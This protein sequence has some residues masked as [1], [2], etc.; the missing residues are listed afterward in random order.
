MSFKHF[1]LLFLAIF[2]TLSCGIKIGEKPPEA[3]IP[4]YKTN[5]CLVKSTGIFGQYFKGQALDK[6]IEFAWDCF[7]SMVTEFKNNVRCKNKDECS[8][9]EIAKFIEDNFLDE[10][11]TA[12]VKQKTVS[13]GLQKQLMK[14]KKLF[15]GGGTEY[16]K[17]QELNLLVGLMAN[18]K[19]IFVDLN[20]SMKI[21]TLNWES[22]LKSGDVTLQ[23]FESVNVNFVKVIHHL[24]DL[25]YKEDN[26]YKFND[27][28]EFIYELSRFS[29]GDWGWVKKVEEFL[30]L[31]KK[32]KKSITGGDEESIKDREWDLFLILGGRGYIQ[33]LRYYYFIKNINP[34]YTSLKLAYYARTIEESFMIFYDL[35]SFK[36]PHQ[37]S[38]AEIDEILQSFANI[39]KDF[40]YS[41][42]LMTELMKIK[43]IIV[44][45][46]LNGIEKDEFLK[47]QSKVKA[48]KDVVE[49]ILPFYEFY[50][51]T[52]RPELL[53]QEE[54]KNEFKEGVN[55]LSYISN[56]IIQEVKLESGYTFSDLLLLVEE[57]EK[58]YPSKDNKIKYLQSLKEYSCLILI[59]ADIFLDKNNFSLGNSCESLKLSPADLGV[60]LTRAS[61]VFGQY[62]NYH[63]FISQHNTLNNKLDYEIRLNGFLMEALNF[64]KSVIEKRKFKII[65]YKEIDGLLTEVIKL[66][67]IPKEIKLNSLKGIVRTALEKI[68]LDPSS[69]FNKVDV[70]GIEKY[71]IENAQKEISNYQNTSLYFMQLYENKL[72][73]NYNYNFFNLNIKNAIKNSSD[74]SLTFG[75]RELLRHFQTPTPIS[76]SNDRKLIFVK[77]PNPY[78]GYAALEQM[79]LS[80]FLSSLLIRAYSKSMDRAVNVKSL[81][82]C[83][84]KEA[85]RDLK[86]LLI[87]FGVVGAT[88]GDGFIDSRFLEA[89]IFLP[90][91]DGNDFVSFEEIAELSNF[92]FSGF[93]IDSDIYVDILKE[94]KIYEEKS[95]KFLDL[96]CLRGSYQ[97]HAKEVLSAMPS[98]LNYMQAEKT[99]LWEEAFLNNLKAAG[100][101]PRQ[102][103]KVSVSDASL[104]PHILQYAE[105]LFLKFDTNF[106]GVIDKT[107]GIGAYPAFANLL[108]KV[109]KK[110]LD[111][112][113]IKEKELEALFTYILKYGAIP[114][115]NKSFILLC[116]FEEDV[117]NWLDWKANY[118]K[119]SYDLS[120][121]RSQVAKILG[122]IADMVNTS[123]AILEES[124]VDKCQ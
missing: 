80:R 74:Y 70:R 108:K 84:A 106:D 50:G 56:K 122:L 101:I 12:P 112:G 49:K 96:A 36:D 43:R 21:L 32:L 28:Y 67:L 40:K 71:H 76:I 115:C 7:T 82:D 57:F 97:K 75:L 94:C 10:N 16:I 37:I 98:Y 29:D 91:S 68:L 113:D 116:L 59:G 77:S 78:Y 123:P 23:D 27:F 26:E 24:S 1:L 39:W 118:K 45:G 120:A 109:A 38:K 61:Q 58:L 95:E 60:V 93:K 81:S 117:R 121:N 18:L 85:Y 15:L 3:K 14:I 33:Y 9:G 103:W 46:G 69:R 11:K 89:N 92:I 65:S 86:P 25:I 48:I 55:G 5:S 62:L 110:Q 4:E 34:D 64:S 87:D 41:P 19:S 13:V 104:F 66:D 88:S 124:T 52:W 72:N 63:Y 47:A 6:D 90:H 51:L 30:P 83:E 20:P 54:A 31:V 102:D 17:P 73:N 53:T 79:N 111:N 35:L 2:F 105:S 100:Y 119:A 99:A 107:E 44:G 114:E 42:A 8:P 22:Q